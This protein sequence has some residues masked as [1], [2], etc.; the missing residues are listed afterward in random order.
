MNVSFTR[1]VAITS[2]AAMLTLVA[3][4]PE[5]R[6]PSGPPEGWVTD[7]DRW[8]QSGVDTSAAFRDLETLQSMQVKGAD[9]TYSANLALAR[10]RGTATRQLA[11]AVKVS[12]LPVLRNEPEVVDSLFER[13]VVPRIEEANFNR[14]PDELVEQYKKEGY[15]ILAR[16]FR[17]PRA[18]K[19]LGTDVPIIYPDS[20]REAGVTGRVKMQVRVDTA[21][22]PVAVGLLQSVHPVLDTIA[23]RAVT[24]ARWQPAYLLRVGKSD[25]IPSWVRLDLNFQTS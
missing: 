15:R 13:H 24:E 7:G 25:P 9:L 22:V 6:A 20:L 18:T 16:H 21:G 3:C 10:D 19:H 14:S 5:S 17:E 4:R 11:R 8:W 2:T 23:M 12:L 1:I